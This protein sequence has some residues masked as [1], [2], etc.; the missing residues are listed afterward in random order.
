MGRTL[1]F[2]LPHEVLAVNLS[3]CQEQSFLRCAL[4]EHKLTEKMTV[5]NISK[6]TIMEAVIIHTIQV[7]GVCQ[8]FPNKPFFLRYYNSTV[9]TNPLLG[10]K[11]TF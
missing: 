11:L 1:C 5:R 7:K 4:T 6:M 3:G 9:K 8:H 2:D 10:L